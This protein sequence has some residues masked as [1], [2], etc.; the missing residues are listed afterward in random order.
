MTNCIMSSDLHNRNHGNRLFFVK[1]G[2]HDFAGGLAVKLS[3]CFFIF[4]LS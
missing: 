4:C 1:I 3:I 2:M